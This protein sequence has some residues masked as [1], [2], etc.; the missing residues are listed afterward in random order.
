MSNDK[1]VSNKLYLPNF[2]KIIKDTV[3]LQNKK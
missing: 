3:T 1:S 2:D